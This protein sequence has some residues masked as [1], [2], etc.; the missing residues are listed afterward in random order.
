[1]KKSWI[2]KWSKT[3]KDFRQKLLPEIASIAFI[4]LMFIY[5][6]YLI[7]TSKFGDINN[8]SGIL[9][10]VVAIVQILTKRNSF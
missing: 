1:M 4:M 5:G 7:L 9:F 8:T 2:D 3:L 10:L 6:I